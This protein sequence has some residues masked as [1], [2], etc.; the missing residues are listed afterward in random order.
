MK[1]S[2]LWQLVFISLVSFLC[3]SLFNVG[4]QGKAANIGDKTKVR[5]I[6]FTDDQGSVT[7]ELVVRAAKGVPE[8]VLLDKRGKDV[9][10]GSPEARIIPTR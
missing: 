1:N 10:S 4:H 5:S 2:R 7:G 3:G 6:V 9:W 8:L